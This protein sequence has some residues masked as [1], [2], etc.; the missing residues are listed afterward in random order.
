MMGSLLTRLLMMVFG[1]VYPAYECFKTVEKDKPEIDQLVF[2][3]QYW[4][5][6]ALLTTC[7]RV[8]DLF[9]SWLPLY[10]EAKFALCIYLWY[11]RTRGTQYI[12]NS[13]LK[14]CIAKHEKEIDRNLLYMKNRTTV[15][16]L[17]V[18]QKVACYGQA[19][20]FE[21]LQYASSQSA[22]RRSPQATHKS[23]EKKK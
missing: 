20:L 12:Y 22:S 7:E 2:W 14:P 3:C 23:E 6:L 11:P 19:K 17:L 9:I 21:I 1:Y 4:I 10:V 13:F 18:W 8:G 16:A 15:V 5:L